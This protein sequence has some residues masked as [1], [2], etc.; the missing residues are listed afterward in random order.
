MSPI[1]YQGKTSYLYLRIFK[2]HSFV[3]QTKDRVVYQVSPNSVELIRLPWLLHTP[4]VTFIDGDEGNSKPMCFLF[5]HDRVKIILTTFPRGA[6][7]KWLKQIGQ[8]TVFTKLATRLWSPH[9]L[10]LTGLVLSFLL[11]MHG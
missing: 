5:N 11:S 3:Y 10:F 7:Q 6:Y 9:E 2:G 4:I 1:L 8:M